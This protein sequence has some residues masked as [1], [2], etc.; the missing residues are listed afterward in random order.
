MIDRP[1]DELGV[2]G[3]PAGRR[4][5][6]LAELPDGKRAEALRRWRVLRPHL[7]D[8]VPLPRAAAEAGEAVRTV[9]RWLTRY[10][11]GGRICQEL[12]RHGPRT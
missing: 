8:G 4:P 3:D 9:Q 2:D 11:A 12:H 6:G 5:L 1:A 7:E 10:R